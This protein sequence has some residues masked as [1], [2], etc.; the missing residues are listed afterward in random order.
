MPSPKNKPHAYLPRQPIMAMKVL[1]PYQDVADW[2]GG[3]VVKDGARFS[4]IELERDGEIMRAKEGG[5]I[6]Q[7]RLPDGTVTGYYVPY[8]MNAEDFNRIYRK[9]ESD[10][11][12]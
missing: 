11:C 3:R 12:S 6:I 8:M 7:D 5:I 10:E 9:A 4:H 1:R 2:C